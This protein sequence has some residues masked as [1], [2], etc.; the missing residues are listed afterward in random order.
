MHGCHPSLGEVEVGGSGVQGHPPV[1]RK[2]IFHVA[3]NSLCSPGSLEFIAI[4]NARITGIYHHTN[5]STL[6]LCFVWETGSHVLWG[7]SQTH[8]V[9]MDDLK[10]LILLLPPSTCWDYR[11]VSPH[12]PDHVVL[13]MDFAAGQTNTAPA[14][15]HLF[16]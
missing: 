5:R 4:P 10:L 12:P 8:Y 16:D 13:S 1:H 7:W 14:E 9:T 3:W 11:C 2:A 6:L 15:R